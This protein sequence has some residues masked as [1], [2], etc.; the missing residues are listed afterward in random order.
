MP[1][2]HRNTGEWVDDESEFNFWI[3]GPK[4]GPNG[5][6]RYRSCSKARIRGNRAIDLEK[7]T[8]QNYFGRSGPSTYAHILGLIEK[9]CQGRSY[10]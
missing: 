9:N 10:R 5:L 6:L 3:W 8:R 2:F 1:L 7:M 4:I